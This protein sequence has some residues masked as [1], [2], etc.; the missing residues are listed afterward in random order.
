[1][2]NWPVGKEDGFA[3]LQL[4]LLSVY[5][6]VRVSAEDDGHNL[7]KSMPAVKNT[8]ICGRV[9]QKAK[10]KRQNVLAEVA[11]RTKSVCPSSSSR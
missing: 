3:F 9:S 8:D 11:K 7:K 4:A 1:M 10:V 5:M 6:T 2:I